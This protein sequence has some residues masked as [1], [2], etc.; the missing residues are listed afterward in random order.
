MVKNSPDANATDFQRVSYRSRGVGRGRNQRVTDQI[1]G[2][3]ALAEYRLAECYP[4][5]K[6][7]ILVKI[8]QVSY[9]SH[10]DF[11][12]KINALCV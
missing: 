12:L 6:E 10:F 2:K 9:R 7:S 1:P 8:T 11:L 5:I 4:S 3:R